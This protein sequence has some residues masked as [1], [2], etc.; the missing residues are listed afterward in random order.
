MPVLK[1]L[2]GMQFG[3]LTVVELTDQRKWRQ[4]VWRCVCNCGAYNCVK[5]LL[6]TSHILLIGRMVSCRKR[7]YNTTRD[8]VI[9]TY[10]Y[11][12]KR[13][14]AITRDLEFKLS[15]D[16]FENIVKQNC[17]YCDKKD[18]KTI[19]NGTTTW[20]LLANG[21]DRIDSALGYTIANCVPC[22][23]R[24]NIAKRTM[25][26]DEYIS[27]CEQVYKHSLTKLEKQPMI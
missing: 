26:A 8:R 16:E 2:T 18:T 15:L 1:D 11:R 3:Y 17:F 5:E 25:S 6:V 19:T 4:T 27:H 20:Q 9:G 22:C 10:Y 7:R 13:S 21:I 14:N 24:C 23:E 12:T